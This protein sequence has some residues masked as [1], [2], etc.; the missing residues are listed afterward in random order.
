VQEVRQTLPMFRFPSV[1]NRV[2]DKKKTCLEYRI[3]TR[4]SIRR[5]NF[6]ARPRRPGA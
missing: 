5:N 6:F 2:P 1:R 3:A 4:M